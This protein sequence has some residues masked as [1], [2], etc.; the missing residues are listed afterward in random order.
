MT[1]QAMTADD[2]ATVAA[3]KQQLPEELVLGVVQAICRVF[4]DIGLYGW[5]HKAPADRITRLYETLEDG[6]ARYGDIMINMYDGRM[7]F[8][9]EI[10]KRASPSVEKLARYFDELYVR[11]LSFEVGL[12]RSEVEAFAYVFSRPRDELQERGG[13]EAVFANEGIEHVTL[14]TYVYELLSKD[15]KVVGISHETVDRRI[16]SEML[17]RSTGQAEFL[18]V[19]RD[20]AAGG[21][22]NIVNL[23]EIRRESPDDAE[24]A[25][26][27]GAVEE[28]LSQIDGLLTEEA[29]HD[30]PDLAREMALG[31]GVLEETLGARLGDFGD[32]E[33]GRTAAELQETVRQQADRLRAE[34]VLAEYVSW[35]RSVAKA[36]SVLGELVMGESE[37]GLVARLRELGAAR[38]VDVRPLEEV[39]RVVC[40]RRKVVSRIRTHLEK[41]Y[42]GLA[43][44]DAFCRSLGERL[45]LHAERHI[46]AQTNEL[47]REFGDSRDAMGQFEALLLRT[48][49]VVVGC[50]G[51]TVALVANQP[52]AAGLRRGEPLPAEL[53]AA[54]EAYEAGE[55]SGMWEGLTLLDCGRTAAGQVAALLLAAPE[56]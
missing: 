22:N 9:G 38:G 26:V 53:M 3:E 15:E 34:A 2:L 28:Q 35:D 19:L 21:A 49:L 4:Q 45:H 32:G 30:D 29:L 16:L 44:S 46:A 24:A 43:G 47:W 56:E 27:L 48:K 25:S 36:A 7:V 39:V 11:T 54:V 18:S 14:N 5:N 31:L 1:N 51:G 41:E 23:L 8:Q 52:L 10:I 37:G 40:D 42:P 50:A 13:I 12:K 6:V 17:E 33:A 20:S 55:G